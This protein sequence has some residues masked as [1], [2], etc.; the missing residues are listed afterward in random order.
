M[1]YISSISAIWYNIYRAQQ[2]AERE[3]AKRIAHR[4]YPTD[5][6]PGVYVNFD[7]D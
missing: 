2:K 6:I 7:C 4:L 1:L 3:N 5:N